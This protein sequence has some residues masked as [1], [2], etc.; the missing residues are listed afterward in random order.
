VLTGKVEGRRAAQEITIFK[1]LGLAVEV[2]VA[3][4]LAYREA[5]QQDSGEELEL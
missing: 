4:K 3:A 2:V 1:S 5:V